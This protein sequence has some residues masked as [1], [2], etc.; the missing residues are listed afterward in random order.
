MKPVFKITVDGKDITQS[1]DRRLIEL[2]V[3][4]NPGLEADQLKLNL[5]DHDEKLQMPRRGARINVA[6]G[7]GRT[8]HDRGT[9]VVDAVE[10]SGP[11]DRLVI[12]AQ[13]ADFREGFKERRNISYSDKSLGD[14]LL[15]V[16]ARY[17]L[18]HAIAGA[19]AKI[20]VA[21]I[22]Q[23][24]ES[25]AAFL[26]RLGLRYDAL[27]SVK[28]GHLLFVPMGNRQSASGQDLDMAIFGRHEFRH[29]FKQADRTTRYTGVAARW[30]DPDAASAVTA[31]SGGILTTDDSGNLIS[32][33]QEISGAEGTLKT[34]S[35]YYPSLAEA[36]AEAD[37][38]WARLKRA[39]STLQLTCPVGRPEVYV[40]QG[41]QIEGW[42][43]EFTQFPW[44]VNSATHK[45]DKPSGLSSVFDL[46]LVTD[47]SAVEE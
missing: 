33:R 43:Q 16:A 14:I 1:L 41:A 34:L 30:Y 21:H 45:L 32:V 11:P 24:D 5:S 29:A 25:D 37:A 23:T 6:L 31:E 19:L 35:E 8:L 9:F 18:K 15:A 26:R 20:V 27:A 10:H 44:F 40:G 4:D 7:F 3:S 2:S 46:E 39:V 36:Q 47:Q 28:N 13:S 12:T 22:D 42:R 38:E 17:D